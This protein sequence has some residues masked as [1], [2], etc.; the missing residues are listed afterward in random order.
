MSLFVVESGCW[1]LTLPGRYNPR[2]HGRMEVRIKG[3]RF[4]MACGIYFQPSDADRQTPTA[5]MQ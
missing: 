3:R 1:Q 2:H 4:G 5:N